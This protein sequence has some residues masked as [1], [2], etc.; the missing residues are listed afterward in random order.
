LHSRLD[1]VLTACLHTS[2]VV[3]SQ[4]WKIFFSTKKLVVVK[5][6][7]SEMMIAVAGFI[8]IDII[9]NAA[10]AGVDGMKAVTVVVDPLRP[11]YNYITC[12]YSGSIGFVY[13]H[14]ALKC[15]LLLCGI[16]LTWLVR[17]TPSQFNESSF[18]GICIYNVSI[19]ICFVVPIIS[20]D[21]GGRAT[22]YL[23][24]AFAIIFVTLTTVSIL[25]IPKVI[26]IYSSAIQLGPNR[27][28]VIEDDDADTSDHVK[29][30]SKPNSK[31]KISA[32]MP[33]TP[34]AHPT[35]TPTNPATRN[36]TMFAAKEKDGASQ[37]HHTPTHVDS[38]RVEGSPTTVNRQQIT[39]T[40]A[41][42]G[43][44]LSIRVDSVE[45]G[46]RDSP[47]ARD[48]PVPMARD[49]PVPQARDSPVPSSIKYAVD[50]PGS[51]EGA[52]D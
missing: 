23:I 32:G 31:P 13:T 19:V 24:R 28:T 9:I 46:A 40:T 43:T 4:I 1:L 37:A 18:I 16:A 15:G 47:L 39:T 25:Y 34:S 45:H 42:G 7:D 50:M 12:D 22:I 8:L 38:S 51:V 48:S 17:N 41:P 2:F 14:V 30:S 26:T 27:N 20:A 49:S 35:G 11:M 10:W 29:A 3:C 44:T 6:K 5:M 33:G 36:N 52:H 21:L